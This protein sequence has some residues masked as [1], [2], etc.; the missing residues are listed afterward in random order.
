MHYGLHSAAAIDPIV[1][2]MNASTT[3][4]VKALWVEEEPFS[5]AWERTLATA[6]GIEIT[7]C[8]CVEEAK[9]AIEK[10]C[11]DA[12]ICDLILPCSKEH[13]TTGYVTAD[14]GLEFIAYLRDPTRKGAT[15][16]NL[17]VCVVSAVHTPETRSAVCRY[18]LCERHYLEKP[19]LN[20][21]D[22]I[23]VLSELLRCCT[24]S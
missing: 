21:Q 24:A 8:A 13:K 22:W 12:A 19:I 6:R 20:A 10:Q 18:L 17:F 9:E 11:F 3:Q 1:Y 16:A 7:S 14:A 23:F 15:P 2:V 5:L 4:I